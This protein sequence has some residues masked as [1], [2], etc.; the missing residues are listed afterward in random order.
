MTREKTKS[1][2]LGIRMANNSGSYDVH[3]E[4]RG[5]HWVAWVSRPGDA[6]PD[7]SVVWVAATQ[8]QAEARAREWTEQL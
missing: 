6:K 5:S 7:R 4:A 8:Q 1:G 3:S 2:K